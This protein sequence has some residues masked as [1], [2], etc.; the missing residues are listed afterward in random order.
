[1]NEPGKEKKTRKN[2]ESGMR[3]RYAMMKFDVWDYFFAE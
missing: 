2:M 1:M 3:M